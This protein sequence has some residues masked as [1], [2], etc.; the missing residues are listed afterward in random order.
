MKPWLAVLGVT[1]AVG[2]SR[3]VELAN[4]DHTSSFVPNT[5]PPRTDGGVTFLD[6]GLDDPSLLACTERP[7]GDCRGANDF[8]CNFQDWFPQVTGQCQQRVGC[9][10]S[11][12]MS[13]HVSD[14]C[15]TRIGMEQPNAAFVTCLAETFSA[16]RCP[17]T[18]E[19]DVEHYLG[20]GSP[21]T[22]A[23]APILR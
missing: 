8:P 16:V 10:A 12:W 11:D 19:M 6:A 18:G 4:H 23:Q 5:L 3:K 13:L 14:G 7:E 2:C 21:C 20:V 15:V 9:T 22:D 1:V 17:C